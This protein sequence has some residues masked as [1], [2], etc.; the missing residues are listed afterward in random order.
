MNNDNEKTKRFEIEL[1]EKIHYWI[2]TFEN[3][4]KIDMITLLNRIIIKKFEINIDIELHLIMF[5]RKIQFI[6]ETI[7]SIT[8]KSIDMNVAKHNFRIQFRIFKTLIVEFVILSVMDSGSGL[9]LR[10]EQT[11]NLEIFN[12]ICLPWINQIVSFNHSFWSTSR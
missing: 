8:N 1:F 9:E 5:I 12:S 7:S 11:K 6:Y 4:K 3:V 2:K 10:D